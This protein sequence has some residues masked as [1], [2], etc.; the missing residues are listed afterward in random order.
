MY[1]YI[2]Q[3]FTL[4]TFFI[5][6]SIQ[7]ASIVAYSSTYENGEVSKV[8]IDEVS[9]QCTPGNNFAFHPI[10]SW[11]INCNTNCYIMFNSDGSSDCWKCGSYSNNYYNNLD[12][13]DS[14]V[15]PDVCCGV[16][17]YCSSING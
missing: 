3:L 14:F 7:N 10:H 15:Y 5:V 11:T 13:T 12:Y 16:P 1:L 2:F 8:D 6:N 17:V 4:L 9:G